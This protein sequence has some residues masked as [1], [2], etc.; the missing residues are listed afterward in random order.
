MPRRFRDGGQSIYAF[1]DTFLVRCP[2]CGRR[3]GVAPLPPSS[4]S[5]G[6]KTG[7]F[8]PQ[9]CVCVHCGFVR[10]WRGKK[11]SIGEACDWY[12]GYPLWLRTPCCGQTLWAY[13]E[14]HLRFLEEFVAA[15]LRERAPEL[16]QSHSLTYAS[17]L[18]HWMQVAA[19]RDD[20]LRALARLRATLNE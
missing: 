19:N 12:F 15:E 11:V 17:R 8:A 13:N 3:A 5:K 7:L 1:G 6:S 14:P 2:R 18:P 9:R 16:R 20:V 10:E 4:E